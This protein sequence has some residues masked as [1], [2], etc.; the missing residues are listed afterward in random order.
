MKTTEYNKCWQ[1]CENIGTLGALLVGM[2]N[3]SAAMKTCMTIS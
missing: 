3:G 2:Q 1:G